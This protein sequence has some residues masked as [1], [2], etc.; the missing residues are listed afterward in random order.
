[1]NTTFRIAILAA[2]I[3]A[4]AAIPLLLGFRQSPCP[5]AEDISLVLGLDSG[6][7]DLI[8]SLES[9]IVAP[10]A[11][12]RVVIANESVE[13]RDDLTDIVCQEE[14]RYAVWTRE[15]SAGFELELVSHAGKSIARVTIPSSE[16][17]ERVERL[18]AGI[19]RLVFAAGEGW[20]GLEYFTDA[21]PETVRSFLQGEAH[22]RRSYFRQATEAFEAA[23]TDDSSSGYAQYRLGVSQAWDTGQAAGREAIAAAEAHA[24]DLTSK[25]S[26]LLKAVQAHY[27]QRYGFLEA[28]EGVDPNDAEALMQRGD[29][30][31]HLAHMRRLRPQDGRKYLLEAVERDPTLTPARLHLIDMAILD[32]D[33]AAAW[34]EFEAF[35]RNADGSIPYLR[36]QYAL[37]LVFGTPEKRQRAVAAIDSARARLPF[38]VPYLAQEYLSDFDLLPFQEALLLL[39]ERALTPGNFEGDRI[40]RGSRRLL[41]FNYLFQGKVSRAQDVIDLL[42]P[43][44]QTFARLIHYSARLWSVPWQRPLPGCDIKG[45]A[46]EIDLDLFYGAAQCID[47][48]RFD[49]SAQLIA[50]LRPL[51]TDDIQIQLWI[52]GL[53]ARARW[54]RDHRTGPEELRRVVTDPR[55]QQIYAVHETMRW[56]LGEMEE[57]AGRKEESASWFRSIGSNPYARCRA[58]ALV[59][60]DAEPRRPSG[61]DFRAFCTSLPDRGITHRSAASRRPRG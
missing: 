9:Y 49:E 57:D 16:G 4:L 45:V 32:R 56:W 25:D 22:F 3:V 6:L 54:Q 18:S 37:E 17:Q 13:S 5:G 38:S 8:P 21:R 58:L 23:V 30:I 11:L 1:M 36:A 12:E 51:A 7:S 60:D 10:G 44:D 33:S 26:V 41:I 27:D 39:D 2:A 43:E 55:I 46:P 19:L 20:R 50:E 15:N 53:E 42:G 47:D 59:G 52:A 34:E 24:S 14:V 35:R 28:F 29:A 61:A 31:F 40:V 48:G